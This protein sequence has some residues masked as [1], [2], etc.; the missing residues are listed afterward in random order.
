MFVT[1]EIPQEKNKQTNSAL[2]PQRNIYLYFFPHAKKK[3]PNPIVCY[4]QRDH[5][6]SLVLS[7]K[8]LNSFN[9]LF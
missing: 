8:D 2:L 4:D 6:S 3:N 5:G 1:S 7:K 9:L